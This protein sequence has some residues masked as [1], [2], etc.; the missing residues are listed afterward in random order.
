VSI[1][2]VAAIRADIN[3]R[4][5]PEGFTIVEVDRDVEDLDY[6]LREIFDN[7]A[8]LTQYGLEVVRRQGSLALGD[9]GCG[10][11][12]TLSGWRAGVIA[13]SGCDPD[14][15]SGVGVTKVDYSDYRTEA[16]QAEWQSPNLQYIIGDITR[17]VPAIDSDSLDCV[18]A[19][20]STFYWKPPRD[21]LNEIERIV[22]PGGRL[23]FNSTYPDFRVY[24]P[25]TFRRQQSIVEHCKAWRRAG[26]GVT[27]Q[28]VETETS[29]GRTTRHNYFIV[30]FQ[31]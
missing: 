6:A 18:L 11:G 19:Y 24:K 3:H 21:G 20:M 28:A 8:Q 31:E 29:S 16:A 22:K 12:N 4:V 1:L 13:E 14:R 5:G 30:D 27:Q 10:T 9:I 26:H 2:G 15:V 25:E 7:D 23:I 17:G